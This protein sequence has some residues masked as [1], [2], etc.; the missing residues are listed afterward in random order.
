MRK[1]R[2]LLFQNVRTIVLLTTIA[3]LLLACSEE[4][5]DNSSQAFR[6]PPEQVQEGVADDPAIPIVAKNIGTNKLDVKP[7]D[8]RA[9]KNPKGDGTFVFVRKT[10]FSEVPRYVI[11]MVIDNQA[12]PLNAPTKLVTENLPWPREAPE[13][14]WKRTNL[15]PYEASS[16]LQFVFGVKS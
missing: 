3:T 11:W 14:V 1:I 16:A 8:L 15:S 2:T 9:V 7:G 12:Y 4:A 10:R 13:A 6:Q 5:G